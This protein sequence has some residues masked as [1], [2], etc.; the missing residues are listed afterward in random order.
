MQSPQLGGNGIDVIDDGEFVPQCPQPCG[1]M[2]GQPAIAPSN[3]DVMGTTGP[4]VAMHGD[5]HV[6]VL[7][8]S[9]QL[10]RVLG[11]NERRRH[12]PD[13]VGWLDDR[14]QRSTGQCRRP[15]RDRL[16]ASF[17]S[18]VKGHEPE[19]RSQ[20]D[21]L[22]HTRKAEQLIEQGRGSLRPLRTRW[23]GQAGA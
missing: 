17:Q 13:Q 21:R 5:D 16:R 20:L 14:V 11:R 12:V 7:Q 2:S 15:S 4:A 19:R 23:T 10:A 1:H 8:E 9:G 6:D 22:D 18:A 3:Q